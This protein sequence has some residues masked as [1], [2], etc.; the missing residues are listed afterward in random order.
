MPAVIEKTEA[1]PVTII[2][3]SSTSQIVSWLT[4]SHGPLST[5]VKGAR[6]PKS[7]F[8]GQYDLFYICELLFYRRDKSDLHIARECS[9]LVSND[10]FRSDWRACAMASYVCQLVYRSA[11]Q[12]SSQPHAYELVKTLLE[13]LASRGPSYNAVLWFQL[14]F[15]EFLGLAPKA[16]HCARCNSHTERE[17][18]APTVPFSIPA[19]GIL[20]SNCAT[21]DSAPL[22][23]SPQ[24]HSMLKNWQRSVS[25]LAAVNTITRKKPLLELSQL[26][27]GFFEY[28]AGFR[29]SGHALLFQASG[30][31]SRSA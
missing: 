23:L 6:R 13:L 7:Q 2:P 31:S 3:Y 18:T 5:L 24:A 28:H 14:R 15:L 12:N 20:C 11:E 19:G 10:Q 21:L 4:P 30:L 29:P 8:L 9:Q 17:Q 1:I 16:H 27:Q 22:S 26:L 25:P